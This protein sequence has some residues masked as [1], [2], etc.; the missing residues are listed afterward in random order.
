MRAGLVTHRHAL[1]QITVQN[2][3]IVESFD[4]VQKSGRRKSP[5]RQSYRY[6]LLSLA[7]VLCKSDHKKA[8]A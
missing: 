7:F 3:A 8:V 6:S 2:L 1:C 5:T 4:L